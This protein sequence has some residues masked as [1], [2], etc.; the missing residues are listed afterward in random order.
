MVYKPAVVI[1]LVKNKSKKPTR[2]IR[3]N[4]ANRLLEPVVSQITGTGNTDKKNAPVLVFDLK[5]GVVMD[6][7][8]GNKFFL[9]PIN[10]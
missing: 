10:K 8:T 7:A 3:N 9:K 5:T 2:S 1:Q 6:E 4:N